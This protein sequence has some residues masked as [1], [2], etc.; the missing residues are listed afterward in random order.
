MRLM[1]QWTSASRRRSGALRAEQAYPQGQEIAGTEEAIKRRG[2]RVS[3]ARWGERKAFEY[4][5]MRGLTAQEIEPESK[6]A[7][8]VEALFTALKIPARCACAHAGRI[9]W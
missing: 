7:S 3:D 2:M 8:E 6:A 4:P 5:L 9:A 1:P